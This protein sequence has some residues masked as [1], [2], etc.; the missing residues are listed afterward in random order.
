MEE[1]RRQ[2][3]LDQ[4]AL[5][6]FGQYLQNLVHLNLGFSYRHGMPVADLVLERVGPTLLLMLASIALALVVGVL[7]GVVS[8]RY[9]GSW[10]D[11]AISTLSTLGFA[12]PVFWAGL[13]LIV[14]FSVHLRWLPASGMQTIGGPPLSSVA[15]WTDLLRHLALPALTL[16]F[17]YLS[18]YVRITRSAMLEVYGLDFVRTARAK[19]LSELRVSIRHVLRNAL[20]PVVTITGLQLGSLLGGSIVV[21][22]VFSWPGLGRLAFDAVFQRDI[23]LLLGIFLFSSLLVVL[24]NLAID[25]LYAFLDPR[26]AGGRP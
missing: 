6:V 23:N 7:L 9:R 26:I 24:M 12:T 8:A 21:E 17:F 5:A 2:F 19:G 14:L 13:M 20:L 11:E 25:V 22:T 3:N 18:V 15:G 10:L 16:S 1:L 4:P